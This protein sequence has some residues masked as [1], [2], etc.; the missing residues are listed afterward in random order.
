MV[1]ESPPYQSRLSFEPSMVAAMSAG[2]LSA[3]ATK[4]KAKTSIITI[5]PFVWRKAPCSEAGTMPRPGSDRCDGHHEIGDCDVARAPRADLHQRD[6]GNKNE[7]FSRARECYEK[8]SACYKRR[9]QVDN[10]KHRIGFI[11]PH[12]ANPDGLN[13]RERQGK[14]SARVTCSAHYM[15]RALSKMLGATSV[16]PRTPSRSNPMISLTL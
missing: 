10:R 7:A 3:T 14:R 13:F 5:S 4:A 16:Q 8:A 2:K 15:F 12:R 11:L 1:R 9:K 6:I